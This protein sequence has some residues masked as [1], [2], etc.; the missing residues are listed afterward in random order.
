MRG[1]TV[2]VLSDGLQMVGV[3]ETDLGQRALENSVP[4]S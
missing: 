1:N 2:L 4:V 3:G